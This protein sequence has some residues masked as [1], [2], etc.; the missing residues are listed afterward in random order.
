MSDR[1]SSNYDLR[2]FLNQMSALVLAVI[3]FISGVYG[4]VKLFADKDAGLVTLI[5][6][7][8]GIL[9]LLGV[10]L[11]YAR[12][13]QPERQDRRQSA[14]SPMSDEQVQALAK[15]ERRRKRVRRLAIAGLILIPIL[16]FSG[17]A[18]WFY[19]QSLPATNIIVL[20]ADFDGPDEKTY[21]VTK[22]VIRQLRQATEKYVDVE[23]QALNKPI[24]EHE[25]S[26]VAQ[27]EGKKRKATIVLWGWYLTP[28]D[29]VPLSVN[30]EVLHPPKGLHELGQA[31]RGNIQ[32]AAI[33]ELKN[34][35]L[36]TRLSNEMAYLSLFVLGMARRAAGDGEGAIARFSDALGQ[37]TE[38]SSS[39]SQSLVYFYRGSTYVLK[40]D[41]ER[42]LADLTQALTLKPTF[43]EAYQNRVLIHLAKGNYSQA[44][45]DANQ[46]INLKPDLALAYNNRGLIYL[47]TN[48]YDR[49]IVDFSQ[50]LK[51]RVDAKEASDAIRPDG[52]QLGTVNR[53]DREFP[54]INFVFT[55]LSDY[56][57]YTNRGLA[58]LSKGDS[59]RALTDFNHAIKLRPD[60]I[61]AYVNR[62]SVY[63]AKQDYDRALAD[64]NQTIKLQP[65]F[66]LAYLKRGAVYY[67][68]GDAERA[69]ADL[70]QAL[71]LERHS[72]FSYLVRAEVY[73]EREDH[74][75][76]IADYSEAIKLQ[77]DL[78]TAYLDRGRSYREQGDDDRALADFSQALQLAPDDAQAYN[79]RGWHYAQKGD[80]DHALADLNQALTLKPDEANFYDS[81]GFAY[82]GKGDYD[83]AIADYNQAL[84]LKPDED[85]AYYHRGI[86]YRALGDHQKASADFKKTL[87]LTK[88]SRRRQD[89]EKQLQQLGAK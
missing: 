18:G 61:P 53:S 59:E 49:A 76:A 89:A 25:G 45:A 80:F 24:T 34:F 19:V 35:T 52:S 4:F 31:A 87:E 43:A 32:Q 36:Q 41:A 44:L 84:T 6:L 66:A 67:S 30:F 27:T 75:R 28:G 3:S 13:W 1:N 33:A 85:Y 8:V 81:R 40:G 51:L 21:G 54:V 46:A 37:T 63:F 14:F 64:L 22:T 82:A 42:A 26:K 74:A 72:A 47:Q 88:N 71:T 77:P 7:T 11:Y 78:I 10:C 48:D 39:L 23:I 65:G 38:A 5:S 83:R 58:Y 86:V 62:A 57:V 20:V 2:A 15:K 50:T 68:K 17:G 79:A 29:V 60:R 56:H 16:S 9:L 55:E 12:F 69:L 73:V 70:T